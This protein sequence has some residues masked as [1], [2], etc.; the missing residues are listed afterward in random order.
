MNVIFSDCLGCLYFHKV[1]ETGEFL[2]DA[3]PDGIPLNH[4]FRLSSGEAVLCGN[5]KKFTPK[6]D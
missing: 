1:T 5:G 3:F 6:E 2:C 4:F